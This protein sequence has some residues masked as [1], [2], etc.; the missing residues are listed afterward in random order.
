M[1]FDLTEDQQMLKDG[2]SRYVQKSYTF[3]V[4]Q[5]A[6][7]SGGFRRE[8]WHEFAELGLL[9]ASVPEAHGGLGLGNV[10][11][12]LIAE[13]LGRGLVLE[14]FVMSAVLPAS[15][16]RNLGSDHHQERFLGAI[17]T[18][19]QLVAVAHSEP[20]TR[21]DVRQVAARAARETDGGWRLHGRKTLVVGAPVADH[22]LVVM[23]SADEPG[24][25]GGLSCFMVARDTPGLHVEPYALVDGGP[26]GDLVL[27]GVQVSAD[28]LVGAEGQ[29][30]AGLQLAI[31]EAIVAQCAE[32]VGGLE[33]VLCLCSD[34]LKT[35]RQFG[36]PIG[37]FQA[38]QHRIAD[39]AI[40]TMQARGSLH[41]GLA[42][43]A[44]PER[45]D[46]TAV[47]SGCKAQAMRSASFVTAQG[48]QLHGGY[49]IAEEYRVGHHYR[50]LVQTDAIL[51]GMHHH[52]RR[53]AGYIQAQCTVA[54]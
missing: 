49:G 1:H 22:F 7:A 33:D 9:A 30:W 10:E 40:A 45:A 32:T 6:R 16:L 52:L 54:A 48:I 4:R 5:Q 51:G 44:Q 18:G 38:L 17:T 41:R 21:G 2:V 14:P 42:A 39:M 15:I 34:Y 24:V 36:V 53:Y 12:A 8:V 50:R 26:A 11:T 20:E 29:A 37:S 23:R 27:D 19:E 46:R 13:E 35:R 3:E 43:L 28:C 25:H 47:I 31:D